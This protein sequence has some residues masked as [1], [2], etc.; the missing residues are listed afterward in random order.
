MN[1][2]LKLPG[3]QLLVVC[4]LVVLVYSSVSMMSKPG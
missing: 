3:L 4:W 2:R 1:V